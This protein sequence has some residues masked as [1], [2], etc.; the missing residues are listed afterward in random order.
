MSDM[1]KNL[2]LLG[3]ECGLSMPVSDEE[4][5][6]N[7]YAIERV[8]KAAL[9]ESKEA[10]ELLDKGRVITNRMTEE[11]VALQQENEKL[12]ERLKTRRARHAS[13][14]DQLLKSHNAVIEENEKLRHMRDILKASIDG[15]T[16]MYK[17]PD[18]IQD[19]IESIGW[20]QSNYS[21]LLEMPN[22]YF[23]SD[24]G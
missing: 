7:P 16:I 2:R 3:N 8:C 20:N 4:F 6:D 12:E 14:I 18:S 1:W 21:A 10:Y 22:N 17:H 19:P 24:A 13:A 23:L 15:K 9:K 11:S 5:I